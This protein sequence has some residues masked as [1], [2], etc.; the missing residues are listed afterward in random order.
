MNSLLIWTWNLVEYA[1]QAGLPDD[2]RA[3]A[4]Q[5]TALD[6][7]CATPGSRLSPRCLTDGSQ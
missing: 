1:F 4:A 6:A 7:G 2:A 3:L 5:A